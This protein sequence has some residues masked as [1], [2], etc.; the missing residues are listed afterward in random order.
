MLFAGWKVHIVKNCDPG[1]E[2]VT[3]GHRPRAVFSSPGHSFSPYTET[4][5]KPANNLLFCCD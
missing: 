5:H 2:N 3:R 4:D 1:L